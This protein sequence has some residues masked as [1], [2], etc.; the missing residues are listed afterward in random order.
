M[1]CSPGVICNVIGEMS[2]ALKGRIRE[3]GFG[4]LLHLKN[5]KLDD[6]AHGI[7]L[8]SCVEENPLRIQTGNRALPISA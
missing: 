3:L 2:E 8:L 7:F 4:E 1:R 5:D 6:R